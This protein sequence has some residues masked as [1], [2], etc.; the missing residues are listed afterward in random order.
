MTILPKRNKRR[1][2]QRDQEGGQPINQQ[3]NPSTLLVDVPQG[4]RHSSSHS[5]ISTTTQL[6]IDSP[7]S[8]N[9]SHP[10]SHAHCSGRASIQHPD[11]A[12]AYNAMIYSHL[13]EKNNNNTNTSLAVD[14][15]WRSP[16]VSRT[17]AS[18][19]LEE[20][21]QP[22]HKKSKRVRTKAKLHVGS[23][24]YDYSVVQVKDSSRHPSHNNKS[25]SGSN[26]NLLSVASAVPC[27]YDSIRTFAPSA[28]Q[29][30]RQKLVASTTVS[31]TALLQMSPKMLGGAQQKSGTGQRS[32]SPESDGDSGTEGGGA[33]SPGGCNSEDEHVPSQQEG[34]TEEVCMHVIVMLLTEVLLLA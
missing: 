13:A 15:K 25:K 22:P 7:R 3:C 16:S 27:T 31:K 21:Y 29:S 10:L 26:A 23:N 6:Q 24:T 30:S 17:T 14:T 32:N 2:E 33:H 19:I 34:Y 5:S 8:L 18:S 28:H 12:T 9:I 4:T 11:R 1:L 20:K